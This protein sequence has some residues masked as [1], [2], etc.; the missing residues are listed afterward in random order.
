MFI[1]VHL[2]F[3]FMLLILTVATI[4]KII[5][6]DE[7]IWRLPFVR[8][9]YPHKW[10]TRYV[11][12]FLATMVHFIYDLVMK[13]IWHWEWTDVYLRSSI[14]DFLL[15]FA[16]TTSFY[17]LFYFHLEKYAVTRKYIFV[18][19]AVLFSMMLALWALLY[20]CG[21]ILY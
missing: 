19:Y 7:P 14:L 10:E 8:S 20:F 1:E 9:L 15:M 3:V 21:F 11:V 16:L 2:D 17:E 18:K 6:K 12:F 13:Q 5:I 4:W